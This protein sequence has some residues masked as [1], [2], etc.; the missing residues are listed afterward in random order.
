MR[1]ERAA[2]LEAPHFRYEDTS[3]GSSRNALEHERGRGPCRGIDRVARGH[4]LLRLGI[5]PCEV[6][7]RER[8]ATL[9]AIPD[10]LPDQEPDA[11]ID[12]ILLRPPAAAD[13]HHELAQAEAIHGRN[14][15]GGRSRH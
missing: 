8:L 7:L 10:S 6:Q 2:E 9:H 15:A 11:R 3:P 1:S 4:F 12:R 13:P 14:R 5:A